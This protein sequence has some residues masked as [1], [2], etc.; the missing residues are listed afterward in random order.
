MTSADLEIAY[1]HLGHGQTTDV[2][3]EDG[4]GAF[5]FSRPPAPNPANRETSFTVALPREQEV[6][7]FVTDISGRRLTTLWNG[8]L[9]AGEHRFTWNAGPSAPRGAG[10]GLYVVVARSEGRTLG[11][12]IA[13]LP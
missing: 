10:A 4:A 5:R 6:E 13:I 1:G 8:R 9:P 12:R 2:P 3:P 7:L 11:R